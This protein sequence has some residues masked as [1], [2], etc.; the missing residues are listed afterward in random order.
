M[1][2]IQSEITYQKRNILVS[3]LTEINFKYIKDQNILFTAV[4][5]LD[6]ILYKTNLSI[7]DFQLIGILCF[8]LALKMENHHKVFFFE[9]II[10]LI[11]GIGDKEGINK[12]QLKKKIR[13]METKICDILDFDFE[14][15]TSVLILNRLIQML[16]I[17]N[18]KTEEIFISIAY[19]FLE[20][21]LYEEQFYELDEFVKALSSLLIAKEI[22][23]KYYYKIGFHSYLM[24]NSKQKKKEIKYF[25]TLSKKV[26]QNLNSYKYGSTIFIKYQH[27]D[28]Q[29]V[30]SNY[31]NPFIFDCIQDKKIA[32]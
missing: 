7:N 2:K 30:I 23:T 17:S 16:N 8:N 22:L 24:E 5:Y 20:I 19:F 10:Y 6:T 27:K 18:K 11:G 26:V 21:T 13:K 32:I 12:Y 25:Y 4:K 14:V 1:K 9:E 15:S 3:W 31:L 28:F 29:S